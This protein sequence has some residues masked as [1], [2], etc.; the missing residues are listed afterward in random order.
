MVR[1][2][3]NTAAMRSKAN[4]LH[5][6]NVEENDRE[7]H[8]NAATYR[9]DLRVHDRVGCRRLF[10]RA[11]SRR[12]VGALTGGS[13]VGCFGL[14]AIVLGTPILA[15]AYVGVVA[16]EHAVRRLIASPAREN[17]LARLGPPKVAS[18]GLTTRLPLKLHAH[19][20]SLSASAE[21]Q[22]SHPE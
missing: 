19:S 4:S 8:D 15:D 2:F 7:T 22:C 10:T 14:G 18:I 6:G 5:V 16:L 13:A 20:T 1:G 17:Q 12:V 3:A 21:C 11:T 9:C